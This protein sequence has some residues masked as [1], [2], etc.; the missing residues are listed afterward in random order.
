MFIHRCIQALSS[1]GILMALVVALGG[2]A[3]GAAAAGLADAGLTMTASPTTIPVGGTTTVTI[4]VANAGPGTAKGIVVSAPFGIAWSAVT[5]AADHGG[6]C[7]AYRY[8]YLVNFAK[9]HRGETATITFVATV[10]GSIA[11]GDTVTATASVSATTTD[12]D[13]TN[14]QASAT[15]QIQ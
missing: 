1:L 10:K 2:L 12:P 8:G 13:A 6:V 3:P 14:N 5:C 4:V 15:V 9:L 11:S 7:Q